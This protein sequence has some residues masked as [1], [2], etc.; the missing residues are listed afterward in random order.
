M[1]LRENFIKFLKW[2]EMFCVKIIEGKNR[3]VRLL[4][5]KIFKN[6]WMVKFF[7]IKYNYLDK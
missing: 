5:I 2:E 3:D 7:S 1:I 6:N 4:G